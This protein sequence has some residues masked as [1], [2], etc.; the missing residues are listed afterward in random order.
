VEGLTIHEAA[1]AT[2]WSSRMLRYIELTGLV[3]PRRS[4]SGY[5]MYQ[6]RELERLRSLRDLLDR[7]DLSLAD[8]G[9]ALRL[10]AEPDLREATDEWLAGDRVRRAG[11]PSPPRTARPDPRPGRTPRASG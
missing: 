3:V 11:S 7:F 8:L 2:G 1:A 9:F 6:S 10:Q 5:R 4:S